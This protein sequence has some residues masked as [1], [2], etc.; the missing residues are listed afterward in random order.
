[1]TDDYTEIRIG[2]T[3]VKQRA[4]PVEMKTGQDLKDELMLKMPEMGNNEQ[5]NNK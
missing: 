2:Y 1:M 3:W 4:R 5:G